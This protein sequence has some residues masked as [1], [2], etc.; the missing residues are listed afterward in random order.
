MVTKPRTPRLIPIDWRSLPRER[1]QPLY[2][3][4]MQRWSTALEWNTFADWEEVERGRQLGT[5][6]GL[7]VVDET[8]TLA[9]WCFYLVHKRALQVGAFNAASDAAVRVLLDTMLRDDT[10][11]DVDTVTL[12]AYSDAPNLAA[13]LRM[14]GLTV[15]RYWYLGRD[16][17]RTPPPRVTDIRRW[18]LDD[19]QAT[20]ALLGRAYD[21]PDESRPFAPRGTADEWLEYVQQLATGA[22]CGRLMPESSVCVPGGPNRLLAVALVSRSSENTAHLVQLVVDPQMQGRQLGTQLVETV[23][24]SADQA[25]CVRMTL[26]V[27]GRNSRARSLYESLRFSNLGSFVSAGTFQPRRSTSVAPGS[28]V[29]TRR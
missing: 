5:V 7:V 12:F 14:R 16:L 11:A 28:V 4:E 13:S 10:L 8:G 15:D 21:T 25:G 3:A 6:S 23:C 29:I 18:R 1:V 2:A 19:V 24:S 26:L 27:G 20:A 17:Q 9:G 22:G